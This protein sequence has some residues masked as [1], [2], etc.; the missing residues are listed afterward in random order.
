MFWQRIMMM[1]YG[2]LMK[3]VYRVVD[4]FWYFMDRVLIVLM[5][6]V[7]GLLLFWW[8]WWSRTFL[9]DKTAWSGAVM[10]WMVPMVMVV[11]VDVLVWVAAE[12][13][14]EVDRGSVWAFHYNWY[15]LNVTILVIPGFI[16]IVTPDVGTLVIVVRKKLTI[17]RT[18]L[19]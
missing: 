17:L 11:M 4:W 7:F 5:G 3:G 14:L 8:R 1:W 19:V 2:M 16:S 12:I 9:T 18:L 10:V 13:L 15:K 6:L